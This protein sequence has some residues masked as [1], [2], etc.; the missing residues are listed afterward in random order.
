MKSNQEPII[1]SVPSGNVSDIKDVTLFDR[2]KLGSLL[3][4]GDNSFVFKC[5]DI[6]KRRAKNMVVKI[7]EQNVELT[8]EIRTLLKLRKIQ[9]KKYGE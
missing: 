9:K 4:N 7:F 5:E 6:T 3:H 2:F 8:N 1:I